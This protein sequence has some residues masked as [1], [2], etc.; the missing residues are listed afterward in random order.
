MCVAPPLTKPGTVP[1]HAQREALRSRYRSHFRIC[2]LRVTRSARLL[3]GASSFAVLLR[4]GMASRL[5]TAALTL[6]YLSAAKASS[7]VT[8]QLTADNTVHGVY[9]DGVDITSSVAGDLTS[10]P[11][12]KTATF[13]GDT[14]VLG[15]WASDA[16]SGCG[17]GGMAIACSNSGGGSFDQMNS[18][19]KDGWLVHAASTND[20]PPVDEY[21]NAWH[22]PTY[23]F[24]PGS[25]FVTPNFGSTTY[26]DGVIGNEDLCGGDGYTN[27]PFFFF[28]YTAIKDRL[29]PMPWTPPPAPPL[30]PPPPPSPPPPPPSPPSPPPQQCSA[31]TPC[32]EGHACVC[33]SSA[34]RRRKLLRDYVHEHYGSKRSNKYIRMSP[35]TVIH[36]HLTQWVSAQRRLLNKSP[37][38]KDWIRR[39]YK[40][41]D[42]KRKKDVEIRHKRFP[43][44]RLFGG[45]G[46]SKEPAVATPTCFCTILASPPPPPP[47]L[48]PP[49]RPPAPPSLPPAPP[50]APP[51]PPPYA[52]ITMSGDVIR[53]RSQSGDSCDYH[54]QGVPASLS[55]QFPMIGNCRVNHHGVSTTFPQTTVT[56]LLRCNGWTTV[57][58]SGWSL[59]ASGNVGPNSCD[60]VIYTRTFAGGTTFTLQTYSAMYLFEGPTSLYV[61]A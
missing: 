47:R 14:R 5:A 8:C 10:W 9:A 43:G 17:A 20:A 7:T 41:R 35:D 24:P 18:G 32:S 12:V 39:K 3:Q 31:D 19:S 54:W 30:P 49:A 50:P 61:A 16:D 2:A 42:V 27:N 58:L 22:Y 51:S 52:A 44:R 25:H 21:G 36:N 26:A 37:R 45:Q 40:E 53:V 34:S 56:Y 28:R 15:V 33:A 57:P 55:S 13:S 38:L 23:A 4:A 1:R 60:G 46:G 11:S 29:P 59:L 48:P 6:A